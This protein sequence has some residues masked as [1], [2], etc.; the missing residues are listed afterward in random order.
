MGVISPCQEILVLDHLAD[1]EVREV[2]VLAEMQREIILVA[3][4]VEALL[5]LED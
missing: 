1:L 3:V 2:E 4:V 5:D